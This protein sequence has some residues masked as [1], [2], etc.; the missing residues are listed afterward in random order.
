MMERRKTQIEREYSLSGVL[1]IPKDKISPLNYKRRKS[2]HS[3][4]CISTVK[5]EKKKINHNRQMEGM[6]ESDVIRVQYIISA[7]EQIIKEDG[8]EVIR[9]S[10]CI[11]KCAHL[12]RYKEHNVKKKKMKQV[13]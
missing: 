11:R 1:R 5:N 8:N 7:G 3:H 6:K 12:P 13:S 4:R 10:G 2:I 9:V